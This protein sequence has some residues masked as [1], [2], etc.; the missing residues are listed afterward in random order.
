MKKGYGILPRDENVEQIIKTTRNLILLAPP[1]GYK[2]KGKI[3][4]R[5]EFIFH[6]KLI[7]L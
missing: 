3:I 5:W 6:F 7:F 4:A 2:K 1:P